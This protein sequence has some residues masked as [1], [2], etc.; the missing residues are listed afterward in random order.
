MVLGF[1]SGNVGRSEILKAFL[2]MLP[3]SLGF[4]CLL[5]GHLPQITLQTLSICPWSPMASHL[6][7]DKNPR[8]LYGPQG[9]SIPH[10]ASGSI[11][12]NPTCL[13]CSSHT[14]LLTSLSPWITLLSGPLPLT[15]HPPLFATICTLRKPTDTQILQTETNLIL[16]HSASAPL[17]ACLLSRI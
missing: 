6:T 16:K 8:S 13:L 3:F 10:Y 17:H 5:G 7:Q 12:Y 4:I 2:E 1:Y 15:Q 11:T 14:V 9:P